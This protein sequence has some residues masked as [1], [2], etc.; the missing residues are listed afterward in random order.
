MYAYDCEWCV[1]LIFFCFFSILLFYLIIIYVF[2]YLL[3]TLSWVG[4][5]VG[6]TKGRSWGSHHYKISLRPIKNCYFIIQKI[7]GL[8][9]SPLYNYCNI[10]SRA[11]K[12]HLIQDKQTAGH[13]IALLQYPTFHNEIFFIY[14][15]MCPW[16]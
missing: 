8:A 6:K 5:K 11:Y 2:I 16:Y 9:S 13:L 4:R 1:L 12:S 3:R 14:L 10:D 15:K 7:K